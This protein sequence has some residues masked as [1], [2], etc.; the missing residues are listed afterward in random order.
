MILTLEI[1]IWIIFVFTLFIMGSYLALAYLSYKALRVYFT[2]NSFS[3]FNTILNSPLAP[4][5]SI[6]SP[7]FN[8]SKT[9]VDNVRTQLALHYNEYEVILVNDGSSDDS[10]Q[11]LITNFH[12]EK[13][14]IKIPQHLPTKEVLGV[15]KSTNPAYKRLIVIDKVN[16]GKADA[17]NVGINACT[18]DFVTCIDVDCVLEQDSLLK[19]IKPFLDRTDNKRVIASGGVVRIANGCVIEN[20]KLVK[21]EVPESFL[22][23]VQVL[24][25]IRAFLLGR[26]AWARLD[27]LLL[28]SGAFGLFDKEIVIKCGGYTLKTVSEDMELVVRMRRYMHENNKPYVAT[29]IPD[30]LCW[31]EVPDS[32]KILGNQRSRWS[33]GNVETLWIHRKMFFNPRYGR[34]GLLSYP[35]WFIFE[36]LAPI[37]ESVG[38]IFTLILAYMNLINWNFFFLLLLFCYTFAILFSMLAIMAEE[39]TFHEYKKMSDYFKLIY[40]VLLEPTFF[41]PFITFSAIRGYIGVMFGK[42]SWGKMTRK[43]FGNTK[44]ESALAKKMAAAKPKTA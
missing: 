22:P 4:P 13:K 10:L 19:M 41:H 29:Y 26:M 30:P 44:Q 7:A 15:Y 31:T 14:D 32:Y 35:Y 8:E 12:L 36:F 21:V 11:K 9:I 39:E 24:E 33:R 20:G 23:R 17:L 40:S 18:T 16:G 42:K 38:I 3:N 25:Y 34:L 6:V 28:I 5:L 27:G 1:I 37:I 43:G 2:K